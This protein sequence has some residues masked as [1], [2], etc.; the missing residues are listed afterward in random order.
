[1]I[2]SVFGLFVHEKVR[3][4]EWIGDACISC[5][6]LSCKVSSLSQTVA[7]ILHESVP[8]ISGQL[9]RSA[10]DIERARVTCCAP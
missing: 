10:T 1:M 8:S 9:R 2:Y 4:I 3:V 6:P 7:S 5:H